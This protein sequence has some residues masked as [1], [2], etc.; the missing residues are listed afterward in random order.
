MHYEEDF[1]ATL[2]LGF[3]SGVTALTTYTAYTSPNGVFDTINEVSFKVSRADRIA[4]YGLVAIEMGD[5]SALGVETG[6]YLELGIGPSF[7]LG[8]RGATVAV[9]V[10]VGLGL[11]DYYENP[12]SG[13][14]EQFGFFSVGGLVTLPLG[15]IPSRFGAWNVHAGVD[16]LMLGTTTELFN[17]D[18]DGDTSDTAVVALFGIGVSY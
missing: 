5:G 2:A 3:G 16:A 17:G 1:Y 15:G 14:N 12:E 18:A 13:D 4:P 11:K 6:T 10:K 9:P 7:A 8:G